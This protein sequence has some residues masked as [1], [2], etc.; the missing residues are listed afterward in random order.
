MKY[1]LKKMLEHDFLG[2]VTL[3][4]QQIGNFELER[5]AV[6]AVSLLNVY[7]NSKVISQS[8]K[9]ECAKFLCTQFNMGCNNQ[10]SESIIVDLSNA[11]VEDLSIDFTVLKGII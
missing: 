7:V 5:F 11:I 6:S 9:L 4:N 10:L 8:D 2:I 3:S 1:E